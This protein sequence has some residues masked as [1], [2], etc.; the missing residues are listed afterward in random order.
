MLSAGNYISGES[1]WLPNLG[2]VTGQDNAWDA[3]G[4][5]LRVN[6]LG[7]YEERSYYRP[8]FTSLGISDFE[9]GLPNLITFLEAASSIGL[10]GL[11]PFWFR[12]IISNINC[13][14]DYG[15]GGKIENK[16]CEFVDSHQVV[17]EGRLGLVGFLDPL[18]FVS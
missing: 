17:M 3:M 5:T 4:R 6:W 14:K 15:E 8:N 7:T 10:T 12:P 11:G 9:G 2:G 18:V 1:G 16:F 13:A